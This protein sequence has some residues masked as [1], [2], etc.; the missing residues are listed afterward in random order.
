MKEEKNLSK[1]V[2]NSDLNMFTQ[3]IFPKVF[4]DIAQTC[5]LQQMDAFEKLFKETPFY[6][7]VRKEMAVA[8]YSHLKKE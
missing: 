4:E 7:K 6:N 1:Q 8:V 5:Y 3:N 2:K